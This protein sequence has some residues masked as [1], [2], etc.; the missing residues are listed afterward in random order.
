MIEWL[1]VGGGIHGTYVSRLLVTTGGIPRDRVRVLDPWDEPLHRWRE[2]TTAVGMTFLRSPQVHHIDG[3]AMS[4]GRFA[5][6]PEGRG[7][8]RFTGIYKRP[9]LAYFDE[10][11]RW[12]IRRDRLSE[13]RLQG[14][15]TRLAR[16]PRGWRVETSCGALEARRVVLS[17]GAV[18]AEWPEWAGGFRGS[19]AVQHVFDP[20][21][22]REKLPAGKI[23]V[24]GGGISALQAALALARERP[25]NVALIS[26]H[27]LRKHAF[28]A[29]PCWLGPKCM[30]GFY[31]SRDPVVRRLAIDRARLRGSAPSEVIASIRW[32]LNR[33]ALAL[34]TAE[35]AALRSAAGRL[36][37]TLAADRCLELDAVLLATGFERRR[38]GGEL[39]DRLIAEDGLPVAPCGFPRLD[40]RLEWRAGLHA[41]GGLAELEL[42]P[43]ARNIHG[44]RVAG[45]RLLAVR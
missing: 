31:A 20:G 45:D 2:C 33:E 23:A 13:L 25:G 9:G 18:A 27:A 26:R 16:L 10:H 35:P 19:A 3:P 17:C 32:A 6:H 14:S 1:I 8:A 34:H 43:T 24:I 7:H 28:D 21:F 29:D 11:S 30:S 41:T 39:V 5:T 44:A 4:L 38:P 40:A 37:L 42:G 15:A 12:V 36:E 22:S